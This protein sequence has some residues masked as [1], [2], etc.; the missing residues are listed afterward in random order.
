MPDKKNIRKTGRLTE[1]QINDYIEGIFDGSISPDSLSEEVYYSIANYLKKGLYKGYGMTLD[2]AQGPD[3]ELLE[4]LRDNV[5]MFGAAKNYQMTKEISGLLVDEEGNI[6]TNKEFNTIA[7]LTYDNWN[8]N[9]GETEYSTAVGQ[10]YMAIKWRTILMQKDVLPNLRY[11]AISD[12][13]DICLPLNGLVAPVDD[14][15][16]DILGPLNHFNC[17]CVLL[18]EGLE[19]ELTSQEIKDQIMEESVKKMSKVFQSNPG[20]DGMIFN[21]YH[22]YFEVAKED[23]KLAKRNFDMPI[24]KDDN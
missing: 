23:I 17:K 15:I 9:W 5:Y 24:P 12:P 21:K 7:R 6:R 10:A 18:Q 3:L 22:P 4:E 8:N 2:I 11:S 20:K 13:C 16:W 1:S 14:P 19:V